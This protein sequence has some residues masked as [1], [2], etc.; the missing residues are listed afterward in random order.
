MQRASLILEINTKFVDNHDLIS[1]ELNPGKT[2][3][4]LQRAARARNLTWNEV[5]G[6]SGRC[7]GT[8]SVHITGRSVVGRGIHRANMRLIPF[9]EIPCTDQFSVTILGTELFGRDALSFPFLRD[10][11]HVFV[12]ETR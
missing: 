5:S 10:W 8:M 1:W 2:L 9:D 11:T 6:R 12:S 3:A 7:V 4:S